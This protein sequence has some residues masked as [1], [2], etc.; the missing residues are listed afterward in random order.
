MDFYLPLTWASNQTLEDI[1]NRFNRTA[2]KNIQNVAEHVQDTARKDLLQVAASKFTARVFDRVKE[3]FFNPR[4]K[5]RYCFSYAFFE[6]EDDFYNAVMSLVD[7]YANAVFS[8]PALLAWAK[9]QD[10]FSPDF[11]GKTETATET[12]A[13]GTSEEENSGKVWQSFNN[14]VTSTSTGT[15]QITNNNET[16]NG[17]TTGKTTSKTAQGYAHEYA[18]DVAAFAE[19][20]ARLAANMVE[21]TA[22]RFFVCLIPRDALFAWEILD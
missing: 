16:R 11:N 8:S 18:G 3:K 5:R 1:N 15:A 20:N 4:D 13:M 14:G 12:D 21:T 10:E 22:N 7:E 19:T 17:M 6:G 2:A 9:I